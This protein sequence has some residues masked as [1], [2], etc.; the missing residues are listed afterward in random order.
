MKA[1]SPADLTMWAY[2]G[3]FASPYAYFYHFK[4]YAKDEY[5]QSYIDKTVSKS[6]GKIIFKFL[7]IKKLRVN[8]SGLLLFA[9]E[10]M[11]S[12]EYMGT[13]IEFD[14]SYMI[15]NIKLEFKSGIYLPSNYYKDKSE[16]NT[17]ISTG[18]DPFYGAGLICT[19]VIDFKK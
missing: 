1:D 9:N 5:E 7:A 2:K 13:E 8:L 4:D 6:F 16:T 19:Y 18:N 11:A 17:Y 14:I 12:Q 10:E 15:D 3:Y